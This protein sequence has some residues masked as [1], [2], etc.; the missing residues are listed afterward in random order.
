MVEGTPL[1]KWVTNSRVVSCCCIALGWAWLGLGGDAGVAGFA[2]ALLPGS[3]LL[4]GGLSQLFWTRDPRSLQY[5][6]AAA[7]AGG[8][9]LPF[10]LWT[11]GISAGL[12]LFTGS[13]GLFLLLGA[14][15]LA[16]VQPTLGVPS[17][18]RS[19]ATAAR[20]ASD[21]AL[22]GWLKIRARYPADAPAIAHIGQK[23]ERALRF[24][25][26]RGFAA[27]PEKYLRAPSAPDRFDLRMRRLAGR[28]YGHL[29]F[30]SGFEPY[31]GEPEAELWQAME[32][33]RTV[34][35]WILRHPGEQRPWLVGI[36]GFRL[37]VPI[38]DFVLFPPSFYHEALGL[39]VALYVLPLHGPRKVGYLSGDGFLD[40]DPVHTLY[41]KAQANWDLR[42]LLG[43][44][45]GQGAGWIGTMGVSLGA[46]SAALLAETDD[47]LRLA[48]LGTPPSDL[49]R[50][51]VAHGPSDLLYR[52][53]EVGV[54]EPRIR[55]L[56]RPISPLEFPAQVPREGRLIYAGAGDRVVTP[57]H[58]RD[59]SAH[60]EIPNVCWYQGGHLALASEVHVHIQ[61]TL[62][63]LDPSR[64]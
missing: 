14:R 55:E 41:A 25:R 5:A 15:S 53:A 58:A 39:N 54:D 46:Y 24:A 1:L 29:R 33:N 40:G 19:L 22:L 60:W 38:R 59:L 61:R 6:A 10:A 11:L 42:R 2:C 4:A 13:L 30:E 27:H 26:E 12:V 8:L 52:L 63:E 37:G 31:A 43:W 49:A 56:L 9:S 7:F 64:G 57:D 48:V 32:Q 62:R 51:Y 17:L 44:L 16:R 45:R 23:L 20:L 50:I 36:H 3:F 34:H 21:E 47:A 28:E 35:A 18:E